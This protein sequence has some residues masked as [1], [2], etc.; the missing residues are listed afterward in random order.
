MI[1]TSTAAQYLLI[2][3]VIYSA[4]RWIAPSVVSAPGP[5]NTIPGPA[6]ASWV[7]G[8]LG[9]LF[10]A[11]GIP[12]HELIVDIY[13]GMVKVYG[14]FGVRMTTSTPRFT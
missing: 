5:L 12:F 2:P 9:Q 10:S 4:L 14:F 8:N 3:L 6:A 11:K 7:L 13:G 1:G